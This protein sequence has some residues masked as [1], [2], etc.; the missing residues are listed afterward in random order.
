[1]TAD[2]LTVDGADTEAAT[3]Q[4]LKVRNSTTGEAVTIGLYAKADNGGD[5][6]CGSITFDAGA[7]GSA[8]NNL[9]KLS[10]DHQTDTT[11]DMVIT[12]SGN[13]GIGTTSP[14]GIQGGN[15]LEVSNATGS[16]VIVFR[17]D[18]SAV[19]GDFC[20]GFVIGNRDASGT[21]NHYAG[22]WADTDS[23]GQ[24]T[25]QFAGGRDKYE[26]GT[27]DMVIDSSGNLLVGTTSNP[28]SSSSVTGFF[29]SANEYLAIS[30]DDAPPLYLN[31]LAGDGDIVRLRKD[32]S[33]VGSIGSSPTT[34]QTY[35]AGTS[36]GVT[37]GSSTL[38]P[39]SNTGSG[40]DAQ[41]DIG[42]GT[43][44]FKDLYLSGGVYLGGTGAANHLD[45]YE[46][47]TWTV[48]LYDALTGGNASSTTT[49]G[50]YTKVGNQVTVI[51]NGLNNIS[52]T[53]MTAGNQLLISLPFSAALASSV[54]SI[55]TD[56]ITFAADGFS[57]MTSDVAV[58]ASK[59]SIHRVKDGSDGYLTVADVVDGVGDI[60]RFTLTYFTA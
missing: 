33:T 40:Q 13:V 55:A 15:V 10:A 11:P 7:D 31:R 21:P 26:S 9:L 24:M 48:T 5:G 42:S 36:R 25:L 23:I 30:N 49:T 18:G 39:C 44:R 50:Y 43:Y 46:E 14:T 37:F 45:D 34:S 47:G 27:A 4:L 1:V 54:G 17:D 16:E 59:A 32:G 3:S 12:G 51:F 8:T 38:Y 2:G 56:N 6:N 60:G 28:V 52:T 57:Y 41:L 53:G 19:N 20:G 22:M 58:A 29:Y 35:F